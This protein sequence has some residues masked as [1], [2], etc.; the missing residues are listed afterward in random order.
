M[1]NA[2][3]DQHADTY[4]EQVNQAIAFTGQD[5]DFFLQVKARHLLSLLDEFVGTPQSCR[6]L[7]VGCG[8]G[9][10]DRLLVNEVSELHGIDI[11]AESIKLATANVPGVCFRSY[12]G[13]RIPYEDGQ[14]DAAF[15]ICTYHHVEPDARQRLTQEITRVV[16]PGGLLAIFEHNPLNPM[17][18][19]AVSRTE[20]D[21]DAVL[22]RCGE[23]NGL[24]T[25]VGLEPIASRSI[26]F[27]PF[28]GRLWERFDRC[29][30][31]LPLG[32]Q[33]YAVGRKP[34]QMPL[35]TDHQAC[36]PDNH[37]AERSAA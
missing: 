12:D 28:Q 34:Q 2:E 7:D 36:Q 26:L 30:G 29:L 14:F 1:R 17:T 18:R 24:L 37:K 9:S 35:P 10:V 23:A 22:L 20:F 3:F 8:I 4:V 11:S 19:L 6:L 13:T 16:R 32:A 21:A 31:W 25:H 33:Y 5:V 15:A 27:T